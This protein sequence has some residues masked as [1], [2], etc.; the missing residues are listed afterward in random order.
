MK[1]GLFFGSFNPLH[2]GHMAI[3]Q[4]MTA[5]TDLEQVWFV[6]SPQNPFKDKK[7]LLDQQHRLMLVRI[8]TEDH[9]DF[10]ACDVEL[11]MPQPSYTADS[12]ARL[13]EKHPQHDF[14][15]IM[16]KDH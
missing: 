13:K 12:L 2:T 3:A 8:A 5:Y 6:V 4:Y 15:L 11:S 9:P 14:S 1:V 16:G 7:S 10:K